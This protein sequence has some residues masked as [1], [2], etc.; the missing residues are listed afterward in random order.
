M[1][2]STRIAR[3]RSQRVCARVLPPVHAQALLSLAVCALA[4]VKLQ[5]ALH[6]QKSIDVGAAQHTP[7]VEAA[8]K[9]GAPALTPSHDMVITLAVSRASSRAAC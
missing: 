8:A 5:V 6:L 3:I 1:G 4:A 9:Q 7:A 2:A